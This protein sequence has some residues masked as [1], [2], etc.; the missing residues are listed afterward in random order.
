MN[1]EHFQGVVTIL[2][3]PARKPYILHKD[4]LCFYSDYFRAAFQGSFQEAT[5]GK[6]ELSGVTTEVFEYFQVWLYTRRLDLLKLDFQT[7]IKLWIFGDQHQIPL[8]QNYTVDGLFDKRI[9]QN[10]FS[11]SVMPQVYADTL[12]G[13]PLRRAVIEICTSLV[14][15]AKANSHLKNPG[16]WSVESLIDL[17]RAVE[18]RPKDLKQFALPE[19]EKCFFH[20][21]GKDEHC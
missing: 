10:R 13:S 1:S 19:R 12:P 5:D 21:H 6:I 11:V 15:E 3:G 18:A 20:V 8:L 7:M 2:V 14:L 17:V 4:L 9:K 16:N